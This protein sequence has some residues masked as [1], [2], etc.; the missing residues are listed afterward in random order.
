VVA[1]LPLD[2]PEHG[3]GDS[4]SRALRLVRLG[5]AARTVFSGSETIGRLGTNRIVVLVDRDAQLGRRVAI[6]RKML[7]MAEFPSRV[8]IE[9]LPAGD[10]GA[11]GLLDE[12]ARP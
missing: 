8:W 2:R 9:G 11:A 4:I 1:D 5:E 7:T 3:D 6:M 12:L 10:Q